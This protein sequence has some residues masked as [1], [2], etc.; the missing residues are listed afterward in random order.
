MDE[1][2]GATSTYEP[3]RLESEDS[4]RPGSLIL[5][6]KSAVVAVFTFA[7]ITA[8]VA[9]PQAS[10]MPD[11]FHIGSMVQRPQLFPDVSELTEEETEARLAFFGSTIVLL[12]VGT[13][14]LAVAMSA[15]CGVVQ[16]NRGTVDEIALGAAGL[17]WMLVHDL[18]EGA[19]FIGAA[20]AG[21]TAPYEGL[22][23]EV[24]CLY[25]AWIMSCNFSEMLCIGSPNPLA[26]L[27]SVIPF[28]S[29]RIDIGK[30]KVFVCICFMCQ[31]VLGLVFGILGLFCI[32][33]ARVMLLTLGYRNELSR[34]CFCCT[35]SSRVSKDS[36]QTEIGFFAV[37]AQDLTRDTKFVIATTEAFPM[38]LLGIFFLLAK[39]MYPFVLVCVLVNAL[40]AVV[41]PYGK[42]RALELT[43]DWNNAYR[44]EIRLWTA[45]G[46]CCGCLGQVRSQLSCEIKVANR[47]FELAEYDAAATQSRAAWRAM[48]ELYGEA[49]PRTLQALQ[50]HAKSLR[51]VSMEHARRQ[52]AADLELQCWEMM[53]VALGEDHPQTLRSMDNYA[54]SLSKL[55]RTQEAADLKL[56]CLDMKTASFGDA[57]P[58]TL[59][60]MNNYAN[61]LDKLGR[62]EEA[63]DLFLKCWDMRKAAL[64][65]THM[66]SLGS[67]CNYAISLG[68]LGRVEEAA[69][70]QQ[71]CWDMKKNA[72][73]Q[74]HAETLRSMGNYAN[75]LGRLKQMEEASD[76]HRQCWELRKST[77]G[78]ASPETLK[79]MINYTNSL[80]KLGRT[81]EAA[82]L[83]RRY[84]VLKSL[85]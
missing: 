62:T 77:M 71:K 24:W 28:I 34:Y 7:A 13:A 73:G 82:D 45:L 27:F 30:D 35:P 61:A 85:K 84:S 57:H 65:E 56:R 37:L 22:C 11:L 38:A 33:S 39:G 78:E 52:E 36:K 9:V 63:A 20:V 4:A 41:L 2:N 44:A 51:F 10:L 3:L 66:D 74:A 49:D 40:K 25:I 6:L 31:D 69:N 48:S 26:V 83:R 50:L 79:S 19:M 16:P 29:E 12:I 21:L 80:D 42:Y 53:K 15:I 43:G 58:E 54:S 23:W 5:G 67:L 55:G 72:L 75:C 17:P 14:L 76:V 8:A 1:G 68:K 81:E 70:L 46:G 64:G 59:K 18:V 60:S 47:H 32:I